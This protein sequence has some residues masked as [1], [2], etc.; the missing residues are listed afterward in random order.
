VQGQIQ[1]FGS[2]C[3]KPVCGIRGQRKPLGGHQ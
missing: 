1:H 3:Q 2:G